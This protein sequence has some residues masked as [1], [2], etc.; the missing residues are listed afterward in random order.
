MAYEISREVGRNEFMENEI[1]NITQMLAE[2]YGFDVSFA[3]K[4]AVGA[5]SDTWFVTCKDESYV[6]KYPSESD[7]NN[8]ALEPELCEYLL[9][10]GIPVCQFI[11]NVHGEYVS[12]DEKNRVFHVQRFIE[13]KM[14]NW[15]EAPDWLLTES[16]AMLGKVHTVLK[17]Y[18]GLPTGIGEGFFQYMTPQ[19]ALESYQVSLEIAKQEQDLETVTDLLYR[20]DLI[21]RFPTYTFD[22]S[23]LTCQCTHGDYF[24]SQL[25]CGEDKINAVIDWTTACVHPVVWEIMRSYVYAAPSCREGQIDMEE[26]VRYVGEYSKY[27]PLTEYDLSNMVNLFYYQIAVCDYYGQ[28]YESDAANRHIYLE[29]A[30][31]STK[32]LRWFEKYGEVLTEKLVNGIGRKKEMKVIEYSATE[33]KENW[34][35][36]MRMCDWRAGQYLA[37]LLRKEELKGLVGETS[38]VLLLVEGE[39]MIS[40]CTL[41]EK[42]D[43]QPTDLIPWIGWVYTFPEYRGHRCSETLLRHAEC[44]AKSEGHQQ[45]H[46][47][48]NH[49]GLYEKFGYEFWKIMKDI[50]GEDSRVY[51]KKL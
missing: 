29:Q 14:Y 47:S 13:G 11:K 48:T 42:D 40:F 7:I 22:L 5:G 33:N 9:A 12:V 28:Y 44:V 23:K 45:V 46:I 27:A 50:E 51:V 31:F 38:K 24:I 4:S 26:F 39:K 21:Q 3:R 15:H 35:S 19:R 10:K 43:I 34:L 20:I 1:K 6:V 37:E 41:A 8:P 36:Q 49:V 18:S 2:Q 32:L 25:I 16:A 30:K 17:N